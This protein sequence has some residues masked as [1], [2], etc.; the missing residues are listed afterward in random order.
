[1]Q[2][3][4]TGDDAELPEPRKVGSGSIFNMLDA[5]AGIVSVVGLLRVFV[6]VKRQS[7]RAVADGV[8]EDLDSLAIQF[9][10][11]HPGTGPDPT[12]MLRTCASSA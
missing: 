3:L 7:N 1:M 5:V 6:S 9:R 4:K 2:R 8:G 11:L 12:A 10:S